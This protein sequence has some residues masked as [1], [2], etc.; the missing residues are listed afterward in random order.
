MLE[1]FSKHDGLV[2]STL[3]RVCGSVCC[4]CVLWEALTTKPPVGCLCTI[5]KKEKKNI[6]AIV[7]A[8][9]LLSN[10]IGVVCNTH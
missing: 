6:P 1:V 2:S 5:P 10:P 8:Q 7:Q 4:H 3:L 9:R